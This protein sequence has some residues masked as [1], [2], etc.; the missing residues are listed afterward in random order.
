MNTWEWE[1]MQGSA[2]QA[3]RILVHP[4]YSYEMRMAIALT[5]IAI[6]ERK[7]A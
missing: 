1:S 2:E 7:E 5:F 3:L 4:A 6:E